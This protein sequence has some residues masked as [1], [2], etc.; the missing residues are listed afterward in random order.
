MT[1][2]LPPPADAGAPWRHPQV[3]RTAR[4][5]GRE[6]AYR[7]ERSARRTPGLQIGP[8]GLRV[9]APQRAPAAWVEECL[10]RRADWIVAHLQRQ[11]ERPAP[12]WPPLTP[13][14]R[15][16]A[17]ADLAARVAHWAPR[18]GV[19]PQRLRL[20][21]AR[22][23]WG[24]ASG[25]GAVSLNWRLVCLPEALRDDVVV[26]ELAH[27]REPHHGAAFWALVAQ[28]LPDYAQRHRAERQ[29][30]LA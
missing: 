17:R 13:A 19:Q 27:L 6:V 15:A 29:W 1:A 5:A 25:R 2:S 22:T 23:R 30:P 20:S 3:N 16:Q 7:L 26:H 18:L 21:S 10:Q 9:R 11:A 14:L 8:D 4:L 24:S 12:G 28:A